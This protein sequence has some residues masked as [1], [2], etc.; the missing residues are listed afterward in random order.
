MKCPECNSELDKK[1]YNG[2]KNYRCR[3]LV[4]FVCLQCNIVV[5]DNVILTEDDTVDN[6]TLEDIK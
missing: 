5:K 1:Y 2:V 3:I 6:W 4:K